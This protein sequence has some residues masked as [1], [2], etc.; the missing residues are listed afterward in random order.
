MSTGICTQNKTQLLGSLCVRLR[1]P[2]LLQLPSRQGGLP[3]SFHLCTLRSIG[4]PSAQVHIVPR[5]K[6]FCDK[7]PPLTIS[8]IRQNST[9]PERSETACYQTLKQHEVE[10]VLSL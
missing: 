1:F 5:H 9:H 4:H 10:Q 8:N 7:H 2:F 3:P 6:D